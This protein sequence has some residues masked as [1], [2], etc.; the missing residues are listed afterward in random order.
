MVWSAGCVWKDIWGYYQRS[1][2]GVKACSSFPYFY[3][4]LS[5]LIRP[6]S[7][8]TD[9]LLPPAFARRLPCQKHGNGATCHSGVLARTDVLAVQLRHAT[10]KAVP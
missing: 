7:L 4:K 5:M 8:A 10:A 3:W 2:L 6:F 1:R 9:A